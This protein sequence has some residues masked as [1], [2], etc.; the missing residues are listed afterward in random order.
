MGEILAGSFAQMR[1]TE[2]M[3]D[4]ALTL[5]ANT[6]M[7]RSEGPQIG[8]VQDEGKVEARTVKL[9]RDFGQTIEILTGLDPRDR[10]ILNPSES[11]VDGSVVA[12]REKTKSE[13]GP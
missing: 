3:M 13:K 11:L 9:G 2:A 8:V 5:P 10:V 12:V 1:F 6:I 7:F 4:P